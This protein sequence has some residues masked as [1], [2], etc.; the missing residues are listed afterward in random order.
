MEWHMVQ[1]EKRRVEGEQLV[2][3]PRSMAGLLIGPKGSHAHAISEQL[4]VR[5]TIKAIDNDWSAAILKGEPSAMENAKKVIDDCIRFWSTESTQ[6]VLLVSPI[7]RLKQKLSTGSDREALGQIL[8]RVLE[9]WNPTCKPDANRMLWVYLKDFKN[10]CHKQRLGYINLDLAQ[11]EGMCTFD[12]AY[13]WE[14]ILWPCDAAGPQSQWDPPHREM[15]EMN[16]AEEAADAEALLHSAVGPTAGG[17]V[18]GGGGWGVGGGADAWSPGGT[19]ALTSEQAPEPS[20][21]EAFPPALGKRMPPPDAVFPPP[22]AVPRRLGAGAP[23]V[24]EGASSAEAGL[25]PPE[26]PALSVAI[27]ALRHLRATENLIECMQAEGRLLQERAVAAETMSKSME[28]ELLQLKGDQ[29]ALGR[30]DDNQID[31]LIQRMTATVAVLKDL[32]KRKGECVVCLAKPRS[33]A[34]VPCGHRACCEDCGFGEIAN[35]PM[36]RKSIHSRIKVYES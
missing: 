13:P 19:G 23:Y 33:V 35:C 24:E 30:L 2:H 1:R 31:E 32:K 25:P 34:F 11:K 3:V 14:R 26:A 16:L 9:E 12:G 29:A 18:V 28:L 7:E 6:V 8:M 10:W 5:M 17:G 27:D 15:E 36:C 20:G 21:A 4:N 22:D